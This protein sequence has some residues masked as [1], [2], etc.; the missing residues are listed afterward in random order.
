MK[1]EELKNEEI[2]VSHTRVERGD[3]MLMTY[4][5]KYISLTYVDTLCV[6]LG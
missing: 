3:T 6:R 5:L 2:E 1:D 4:T